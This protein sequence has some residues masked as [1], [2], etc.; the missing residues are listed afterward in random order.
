MAAE[1]A[2]FSVSGP[3]GWQTAAVLSAATALNAGTTFAADEGDVNINVAG[4]K[5]S[6]IKDALAF[7]AGSAPV[8]AGGAAAEVRNSAPASCLV[9]TQQPILPHNAGY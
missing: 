3:A 4:V 6:G 5:H 9:C 1:Q 2:T 7:C 8:G